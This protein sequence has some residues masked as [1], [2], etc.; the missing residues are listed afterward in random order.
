[1]NKNYLHSAFLLL[2]SLVGTLVMT[3]SC[4]EEDGVWD[5]YYNWQSRNAHWYAQVADTARTAIAE[6]K[7]QYGDAWE[8]HCQWRMYKSLLRAQDHNSGLT[9][10]SICVRIVARGEHAGQSEYMAN[11]NDTVS[12]SFRGWLMPTE[13]DEGGGEL[14]ASQ[15]VFSQ[16]YY[17]E[18]NPL[19]VAPSK[20]LLNS[21]VEGYS[22]ALQYM[23][24][25]DDWCVY[26]P[27]QL[28]YGDS[29]KNAAIPA[30][31]TLL[32]RINMAGLYRVGHSD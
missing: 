30:Y 31:S 26:I 12:L 19:T 15:S 28:G 6:A 27:Q 3:T 5:P 10:D 7:A 23:T 20:M 22:T 25:G 8:Q 4:S 29:K 32:F 21:T 17:G 1:M 11:Y 24:V 18:F 13:Y 14:R 2:L 9:E 16:T